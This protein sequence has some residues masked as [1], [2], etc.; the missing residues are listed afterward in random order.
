MLRRGWPPSPDKSVMTHSLYT[1]LIKWPRV[2]FTV[3]TITQLVESMINWSGWPTERKVSFCLE[4]SDQFF[5]YMYMNLRTWE[6]VYV[7]IQ[8]FHSE[9]FSECTSFIESKLVNKQIIIKIYLELMFSHCARMLSLLVSSIYKTPA[10]NLPVNK[11]K[12]DSWFSFTKDSQAVKL[13]CGNLPYPYKKNNSNGRIWPLIS[14]I[15]TK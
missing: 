5:E 14:L 7:E 9:D 1:L 10:P 8:V 12:P 4:S 11:M 2:I 6:L 15:N 3:Y 13:C